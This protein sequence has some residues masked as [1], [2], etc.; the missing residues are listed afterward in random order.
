MQKLIVLA[1][2][3]VCTL[4]L[5]TTVTT[6]E[7][8]ITGRLVEAGCA[9]MGGAQPSPEHVACMVRCAQNGDP[10]GIQTDAGLYKITGEWAANNPEQLAQ[11]MATQVRATGEPSEAAGEMLL[12]VSKIEPAE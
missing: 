7:E 4:G 11:L 5:M 9:A 6:A 2:A 3:A 8:T 12:E 1:L 10:I